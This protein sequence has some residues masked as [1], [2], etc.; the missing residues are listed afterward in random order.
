MKL[1]GELAK[2][3][4]LV[5]APEDYAPEVDFFLPLLDEV[6]SA[7][8][9]TLLELGSG[10]GNNAS[11]MKRDFSTVTLVDLSPQMLEVSARLNPDCAHV[12]GD[13]R[14]VRLGRSFD[15][16]F[17]HDAID[18]MTTLAALRE[19]LETAWLHCREG[20]MALFVPDHVRET[21]APSTDH[22]GADGDSCSVRYLE[23][24]RDPNPNDTTFVTDYV[25]I[26]REEGKP[27]SVV[28]D[29]HVHGIFALEDWLRL[30]HDVGFA[31]AFVIDDYERH[32]F[33]ARKPIATV[34]PI[35]R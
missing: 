30:L 18:Y 12:Q 26:V 16:V 8:N 7:G 17:V 33:V 11:Y 13:M 31:A 9:A 4:P 35:T 32:V 28:H 20:G 5:S 34:K 25:I 1:Y 24:S 15:V 22:G 19:V 21:F 3:W 27:V 10:G 2:W 6:T 23:W 29:E 14:S